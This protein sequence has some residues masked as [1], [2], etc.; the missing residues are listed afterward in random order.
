LEIGV[1]KDPVHFS[2]NDTDLQPHE[3]GE[4]TGEPNGSRSF[5]AMSPV[6]K[7]LWEGSFGMMAFLKVR[8]VNMATSR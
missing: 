7:Q 8:L 3:A 1:D 2:Q 6:K 4:Y 5:S